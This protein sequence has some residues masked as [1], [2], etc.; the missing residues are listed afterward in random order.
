MAYR[1]YKMLGQN[2]LFQVDLPV[3]NSFFIFQGTAN[4]I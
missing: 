1:I 3:D 2:Y 4:V